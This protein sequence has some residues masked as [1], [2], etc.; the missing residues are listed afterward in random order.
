[1]QPGVS[2]LLICSFQISDSKKRLVTKEESEGEI[3][4]C[5]VSICVAK[6]DQPVVPQVR[7][8]EIDGV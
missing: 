3:L 5:F 1:M 6:F 8:F 2:M 4:A 7:V